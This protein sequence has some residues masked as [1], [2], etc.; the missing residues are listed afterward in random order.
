VLN[1]AESNRKIRNN[2]YAFGL[3]RKRFYFFGSE[4]IMKQN[5][6]SFIKAYISV[7][8]DLL[9]PLGFRRKGRYF[10]R[11]VND[12]FQ[13]LAMQR[14]SDGG[15]AVYFGFLPFCCGIETIV[16]DGSCFS[17]Q[18]I[19]EPPPGQPYGR[20]PSHANDKT[21]EDFHKTAGAL[22]ELIAAHVIPVY[23]RVVDTATAFAEWDRIDKLMQ[24][25]SNLKGPWYISEPQIWM[26]ISLGKYDF[27]VDGLL[28]RIEIDKGGFKQANGEAFKKQVKQHEEIIGRIQ[29]GDM[30]FLRSLI[31]ENER[32]SRIACGLPPFTGAS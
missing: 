12:V 30:E 11:I 25:K 24:S 31:C 16:V 7:C 20:L 2:L 18:P 27:A 4:I 14:Y 29:A 19:V 32:M 5:T 10:Y 21:E 3:Y 13:D 26:A 17:L 9:L 1:P 15:Y 22:G 28:Q 8:S 6:T 23:E